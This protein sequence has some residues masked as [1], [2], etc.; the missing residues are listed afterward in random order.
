MSTSPWGMFAPNGSDVFSVLD[1][2][3][4]RGRDL[5][6]D[7]DETGHVTAWPEHTGPRSVV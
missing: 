1:P 5:S 2:V 6:T 7:P 4:V 3:F